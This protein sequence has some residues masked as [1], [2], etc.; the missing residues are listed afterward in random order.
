M[1]KIFKNKVVRICALCCLAALILGTVGILGINIYV[2]ESSKDR[3]ITL[4]EAVDV[5]D[6]DCVLVLGCLVKKDGS[7]SPMLN[8]RMEVGVEAYYALKVDGADTKLLLSGDHGRDDYNEVEAMKRYAVDQGVDSKD[9]FMDHAG[10]S[11]YESIHRAKEIF[12]AKKI[13]IITQEYHLYRAISIAESLGVEAYGI[14]A[15]LREYSG[16]V[17]Y[18]ARELLARTKDFFTSIFKPEPTYLGDKIDLSGDGNV[19]NG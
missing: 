14:S 17:K 12:G 13:L 10:F 5:G 7:L 18:S 15:D 11:T 4:D 9:I 1:K 16:Q 3:I 19:T 8:D 2:V 6:F